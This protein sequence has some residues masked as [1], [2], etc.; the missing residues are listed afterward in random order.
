MIYE[1]SITGLDHNRNYGHF[2]VATQ[3]TY[4]GLYLHK[5]QTRSGATGN[6]HPVP[7]LRGKLRA[8]HYVITRLAY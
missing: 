6:A 8:F 5:T 1:A 7:L 3:H 2:W 4:L